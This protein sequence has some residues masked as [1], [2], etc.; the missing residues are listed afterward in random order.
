[1][2]T[3]DYPTDTEVL[4]L[5]RRIAQTCGGADIGLVATACLNVIA[6]ACRQIAS[7]GDDTG[8]VADVILATRSCADGLELIK[9]NKVH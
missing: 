2:A 6:G 4:E 8:F 1:M 7:E 5:T 9:P 3:D